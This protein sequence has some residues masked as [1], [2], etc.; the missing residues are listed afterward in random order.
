MMR[1]N[2]VKRVLFLADRVSLVKQA[3]REFGKNLSSA[4]IVNLLDSDET[5]GRVYVSTYPTMLNLINNSKDV[6]R[7]FG[8][9]FFDLVI[10]DEAHRS[11]Y[12]KYGAIFDYFDSYLVGLT[13]TPKNEVDFN[14]YRLFQLERGVPTFA[15]SLDDAISEK[16][17]S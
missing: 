17:L 11:I 2:Y 16:Y 3:A 13:A 6:E 5:T 12:A 10:V 9:G 7:R 14:T 4:G 1:C 8:V 15:Y